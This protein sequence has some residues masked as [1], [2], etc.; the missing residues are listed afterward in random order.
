MTTTNTMT[1]KKLVLVLSLAI[2]SLVTSWSHAHTKVETAEPKAD[3]ELNEPP[4]EI[5]LHFS[6]TLEPA[7]TKIVLLDAKNVTIKL[8]K[9]VVDK[10]D[11]KTVSAQLP[12]LRAGQYLVRW[13]TMTRDS[14]KV[15]GEYR[16][17]VK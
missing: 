17:N 11:A 14:H 8:P 3:S 2:G 15:K 5:R 16:F 10:A 1:T 7:F 6:D 12:V 13:S 4:K 9:A